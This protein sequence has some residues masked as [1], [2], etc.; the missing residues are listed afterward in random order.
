[1]KVVDEV[2]A[3][4]TGFLATRT[5]RRGFLTR[6][7]VLDRLCGPLCDAV[8]GEPGSAAELERL[9]TL[10]IDALERLDVKKRGP[11]CVRDARDVTRHG[12]G[13]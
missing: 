9:G 11:A 12:C 10:G 13:A 6:T 3:T 4:V 2:L 8:L 5:S 7:A 1:M